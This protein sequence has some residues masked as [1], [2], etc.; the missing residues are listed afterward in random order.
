MG[1]ALAC[2]ALKVMAATDPLSPE[3]VQIDVRKE[4]LDIPL[5]EI[6]EDRLAEARRTFAVRPLDPPPTDREDIVKRE[7]I[8]LAEQR[9]KDP[10]AHA[11]LMAVRIGESAIIGIPGEFFSGLGRQI[12]LA[13]RW[14]PTFVIELA[15]GCVGY[16]PTAEAFTGG[17]YETEL[18]RSSKLIPDA[19]DMIVQK[20]VELLKF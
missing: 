20:A 3:E 10:C 14:K 1:L 4:Y 19:G 16:V 8:L 15:N 9:E 11:E 7:L 13:S 18:V 2:E 5:R 17:G 6:P 12:K